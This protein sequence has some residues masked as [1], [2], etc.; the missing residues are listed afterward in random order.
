MY[1]LVP[2]DF[3]FSSDEKT[4]V[5]AKLRGKTH[6]M[7]EGENTG[8]GIQDI[9]MIDGRGLLGGLHVDVDKLNNK[10]GKLVV[11]SCY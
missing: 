6:T 4:D 11:S 7:V 1:L 8:L 9:P 10:L 3:K 5:I 2:S